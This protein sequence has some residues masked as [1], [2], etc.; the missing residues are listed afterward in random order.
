MWHNQRHKVASRSTS[1]FSYLLLKF[2]TNIRFNVKFHPESETT[3]RH[4]NRPSSG[5]ISASNAVQ[6]Y[7]PCYE[8]TA[9]HCKWSSASRTFRER[10]QLKAARNASI[11]SAI[12]V[13]LSDCP[14]VQLENWNANLPYKRFHSNLLKT[15][16]CC[17]HTNRNDSS[18]MWC[19]DIFF[20]TPVK[21]MRR[22][23]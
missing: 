6:L 10:S 22:T 11:R 12:P 16:P 8:S 2:Y 7:W 1:H 19:P 5:D 23:A 14:N 18:E 21:V 17:T 15:I 20:G 3:G 9:T 4:H 13:C